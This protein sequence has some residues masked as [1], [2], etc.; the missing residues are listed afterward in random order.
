MNKKT[1][2]LRDSTSWVCTNTI[3]SIAKANE[4]GDDTIKNYSQTI[5]NYSKTIKNYSFL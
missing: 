2:V 5:K 1:K 3:E 4:I